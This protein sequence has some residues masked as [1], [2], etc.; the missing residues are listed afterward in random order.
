MCRGPCS[1]N[2]CT[3]CLLASSQID[4][5]LCRLATKLLCWTDA[6][7]AASDHSHHGCVGQALVAGSGTV[8]SG[9]GGRH[10]Q[11]TSGCGCGCLKERSQVAAGGPFLDSYHSQRSDQ[12]EALLFL[13]PGRSVGLLL[14]LQL[15]PA[16]TA[17]EQVEKSSI[18]VE[19]GHSSASN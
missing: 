1:W 11:E 17:Q 19:N 3:R 2:K 14:D 6:W 15:T 4:L 18:S 10:S 13:T 8:G 7:A 5:N 12:S 16:E 9:A